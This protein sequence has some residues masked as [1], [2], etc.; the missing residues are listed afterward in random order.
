MVVQPTECEEIARWTKAGN[1]PD[2]NSRNIGPVAKFFPLM[3]IGQMHL[4]RRQANRRNGVPDCD[5]GVGIGG[6]V[7]DDP[8]VFR[9]SLLNPGDQFALAIRL[10]E[11][12]FHCQ[13]LR[14]LR[15]GRVQGIEG[16]GAVNRLFPGPEEIQIRAVQDSYSQHVFAFTYRIC[17]D[18]PS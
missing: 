11:V 1:L 18:D 5:T 3:N 9:P 17:G 4:N 13:L 14:Q 8:I 16:Q 2:S 12:H 15:D 6:R 10:A 7:N